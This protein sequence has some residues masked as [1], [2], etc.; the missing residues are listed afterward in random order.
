MRRVVVLLLLSGIAAIVH[1]AAAQEKDERREHAEYALYSAVLDGIYGAADA[2]AHL[3]ADSTRGA[4]RIGPDREDLIVSAMATIT[5][6]PGGLIAD[7]EAANRDA[8]L[9]GEQHF[10][11][12]LPT[13]VLGGSGLRQLVAA[14]MDVEGYPEPLPARGHVTFSRA[15]FSGD[16]ERAIVYVEYRCGGRCGSAQ[17]VLLEHH[18]DRWQ[19]QRTVPIMTF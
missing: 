4:L 10:A 11:T 3:V 1:P 15:G 2:R 5:G 12:G 9:L 14:T 8:R 16:G 6:L 7:Y 17:L 13:H 18:G 19:V